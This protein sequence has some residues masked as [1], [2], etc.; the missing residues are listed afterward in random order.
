MLFRPS[1]ESFSEQW[2]T[3]ATSLSSSLERNDRHQVSRLKSFDDVQGLFPRKQASSLPA[4][5]FQELT[6]LAHTLKKLKDFMDFVSEEAK[7][8]ID[9]SILWG[10]VGLVVL[11]PTN[12][13]FR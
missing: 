13:P 8:S 6:A 3:S 10:L 4:A 1:A 11:V 12:L 2:S 9:N 5:A 7:P